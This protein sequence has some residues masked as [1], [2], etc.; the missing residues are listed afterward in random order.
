MTVRSKVIFFKGNDGGSDTEF[1][2]MGMFR[3]LFDNLKMKMIFSLSKSIRKVSF[4]KPNPKCSFTDD[5]AV[6]YVLYMCIT[7]SFL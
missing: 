1:S 4:F 5:N 2:F 6:R 7:T 3:D